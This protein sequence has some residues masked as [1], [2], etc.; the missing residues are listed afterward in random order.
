M[1]LRAPSLPVILSEAKNLTTLRAGSGVAISG[2][3]KTQNDRAKR[4]EA[5]FLPFEL[6]R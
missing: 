2:K 5:G 1:S 4:K 6:F 3:V